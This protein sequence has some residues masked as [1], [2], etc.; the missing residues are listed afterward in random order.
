[1]GEFIYIGRH[2]H[3]RE[4]GR[5]GDTHSAIRISQRLLGSESV[6]DETMA[7]FGEELDDF[8]TLTHAR[9]LRTVSY[10]IT[11]YV[12][13]VIKYRREEI[14]T[15]ILA[16]SISKRHRSRTPTWPIPGQSLTRPPIRLHMHCQRTRTNTH[17]RQHAYTMCI[18]HARTH[19]HIH[20][21]VRTHVKLHTHTRADAHQLTHTLT[22]THT[23][24][25]PQ[26][27]PLAPS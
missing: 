1:M 13:S 4:R 9:F 17:A 16:A 8:R 5:D 2:G 19:S 20:T 11:H 26:T 18:T 12:I 3:V 22:H 25:Y 10:R 7:I 21:H 14:L 15:R 6:P 27:L 24:I 23:R